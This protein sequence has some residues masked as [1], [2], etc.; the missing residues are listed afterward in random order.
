MNTKENELPFYTEENQPVN[1]TVKH[2]KVKKS[3]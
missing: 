1:L 2:K 3:S